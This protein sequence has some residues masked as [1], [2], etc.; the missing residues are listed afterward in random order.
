MGCASTR[1]GVSLL[2]V[3]RKALEPK[4][5]TAVRCSSEA[6]PYSTNSGK[7]Q[8]Y[9]VPVRSNGRG[10]T[11]WKRHRLVGGN[12]SG[13]HRAPVTEQYPRVVFPIEL[14]DTSTMYDELRGRRIELGFAGTTGPILEKDMDVEVLSKSHHRVHPQGVDGIFAR[15]ERTLA[16]CDLVGQQRGRLNR[17][18]PR[19]TF[20]YECMK[21]CLVAPSCQF[22]SARSMVAFGGTAEMLCSS[23]PPV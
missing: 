6:S 2:D 20:F 22:R 4:L 19:Q 23:E 1:F 17:R 13:R 18:H 21:F 11:H 5:N 7:G 10:I 14:G 16:R 12:R 3:V 15:R 9:R 8:G